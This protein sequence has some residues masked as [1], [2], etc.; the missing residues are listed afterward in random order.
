[1]PCPAHW[2][3]AI[4]AVRTGWELKGGSSPVAFAERKRRSWA[5]EEKE[6]RE[7]CK[8]SSGRIGKG[9]ES[10][11]QRSG[12]GTRVTEDPRWSGGGGRVS[13]GT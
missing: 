12:D 7:D 1:M 4:G 10:R 5:R 6:L 3:K 13:G 11:A 8:G 2:Q 9:L